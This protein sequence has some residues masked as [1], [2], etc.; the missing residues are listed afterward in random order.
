MPTFTMLSVRDV[1]DIGL[2][3]TQHLYR[4]PWPFE[5]LSYRAWARGFEAP[6]L[7]ESRLRRRFILSGAWA[8]AEREWEAI[9]SLLPHDGSLCDIGCGH[10][11]I[12]L[13]ASKGAGDLRI[14]LIDI[15]RTQEKHHEFSHRGAGYS[16]LAQAKA[17]LVANGIAP[18][19]IAICNPQRQP[20]P[21]GPFDLILS[22]Y[23]AGFHYPIAEYADFA[24]TTLKPGGSLVFDMREGVDQSEALVGFSQVRHLDVSRKGIRM[25]ATK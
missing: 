21:D 22:L 19:R 25:V 2:Q 9:Q 10:A 18:A 16:N 14:T 5:C 12:D 13:A 1:A 4:L 8:D 23:S 3:R 24:L 7:L 11:F 15:E 20:L 6:L 17:F